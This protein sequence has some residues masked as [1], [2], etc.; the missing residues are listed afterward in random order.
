MCLTF[1]FQCIPI[2]F[3]VLV[4]L[5]VG[6]LEK[7]AEQHSARDMPC[8][9]CGKLFTCKNNLRKHLYLHGP[10]RF[11][12]DF[13]NCDKKF[14]VIELLRFHRKVIAEKL[15]QIFGFY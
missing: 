8:E 4:F 10:P 15:L 12:C 9:F 13:P 3:D 1:H 6:I 5:T 2:F 14:Q 7:H 11:T